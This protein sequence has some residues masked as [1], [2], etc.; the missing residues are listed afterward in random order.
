MLKPL[1]P[2]PFSSNAK[3]L[4]PAPQSGRG[5][6]FK[7]L[8]WPNLPQALHSSHSHN[9]APPPFPAPLCLLCQTELNTLMTTFSWT[10]KTV[11]LPNFLFSLGFNQ[12]L[13]RSFAWFTL[14]VY[15]CQGFHRM[16][17]VWEMFSKIACFPQSLRRKIILHNNLIYVFHT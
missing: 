7:I 17:W 12:R 9:H 13:F 4:P 15:K 2:Q 6:I 16:F 1:P 14:G 5:G 11:L 8:S 10:C 3:M